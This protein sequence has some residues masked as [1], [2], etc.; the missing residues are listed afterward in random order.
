M[1]TAAVT[2]RGLGT[3]EMDKIA[4]FIKL[5]TEDF[6]GNADKVRAGVTEICKKFPLYE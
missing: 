2:T 5:V 3:E 1:G 4:E 6:E